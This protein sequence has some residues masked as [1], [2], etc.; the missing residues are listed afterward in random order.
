MFGAHDG[1]SDF[2]GNISLCTLCVFI[3]CMHTVCKAVP[4]TYMHAYGA[5]LHNS[6]HIPHAPNTRMPSLLRM[7]GLEAPLTYALV[8]SIKCVYSMCTPLD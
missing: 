6:M 3:C 4:I 5:H 1:M 2:C 8:I 7:R